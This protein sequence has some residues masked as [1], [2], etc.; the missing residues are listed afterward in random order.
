M[1]LTLSPYPQ[2]LPLGEA[3][4]QDRSE[5]RDHARARRSGHL[6]RAL[7][8]LDQVLAID[9]DEESERGFERERRCESCS[10]FLSDEKTRADRRA[11]G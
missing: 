9:R 7:R 6:E 8:V 2:R 11:E 1:R 5:T 3:I 10:P 4:G